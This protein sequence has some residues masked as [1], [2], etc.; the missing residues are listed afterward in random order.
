MEYEHCQISR[1]NWFSIL[2]QLLCVVH[3][4]PNTYGSVCAF[5]LGLILRLGGGEPA[6]KLDPFIFYPG[7]SN[8]PYKT[9]SM[10]VSLLALLIVSFIVQ[11]LF[12]ARI[13][14]SKYDFFRC[15]LI[16]GGRSIL[17]KRDLESKSEF[18]NSIDVFFKDSD[19][20]TEKE[21]KL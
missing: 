14:P 5:V 13:I 11:H 2:F 15:N 6:F 4:N 17:L 21:T 1:I 19:E 8:F 3:F 12:E 10:L 18:E 16:N 7:G 20:V 9:F